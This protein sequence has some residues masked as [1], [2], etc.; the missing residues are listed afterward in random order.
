MDEH[1]DPRFVVG[2]VNDGPWVAMKG[3]EG[4]NRLELELAEI[5]PEEGRDYVLQLTSLDEDDNVLWETDLL[6]HNA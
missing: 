1:E 4:I 6:D 5:E 3:G 2:Y